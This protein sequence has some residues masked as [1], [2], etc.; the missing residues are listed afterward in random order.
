[1]YNYIFIY[2][3][4]MIHMHYVILLEGVTATSLRELNGTC[5]G[6]PSFLQI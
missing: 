3:H 4:G 5:A 2:I 6:C 1:M